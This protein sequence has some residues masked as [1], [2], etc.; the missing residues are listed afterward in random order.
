VIA[1]GSR[2]MQ[3]GPQAISR[4]EQLARRRTDLP[5]SADMP[6]PSPTGARA[7]GLPDLQPAPSII[8]ISGQLILDAAAQGLG[9]RFLLEG[10]SVRGA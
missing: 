8:S 10:P 1:I 9:V 7:I 6:E 5:A 4:P 2:E 3:S